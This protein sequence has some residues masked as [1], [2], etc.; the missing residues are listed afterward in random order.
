MR[1]IEEQMI[2]AIENPALIFSEGS[3]ASGNTSVE[4]YVVLGGHCADVYL[5]GNHIATIVLRDCQPLSVRLMD[6]GWQTRTTKSRLNAIAGWA[7]VGRI[8]QT[9]TIWRVPDGTRFNNKRWFSVNRKTK[10]A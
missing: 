2:S 3:W 7:G 6:A 4:H 10:S 5:H 1:K 9:E 8:Y